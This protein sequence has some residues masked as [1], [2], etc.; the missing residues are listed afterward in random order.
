MLFAR[1]GVS[2]RGAD[3]PH[4]IV[5]QAVCRAIGS[6]NDVDRRSGAHLPTLNQ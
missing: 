4:S 1:Y 2:P 6:T 5:L 3:G